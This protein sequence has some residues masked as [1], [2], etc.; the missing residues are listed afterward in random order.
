[1]T[2]GDTITVT[3]PDGVTVSGVTSGNTM[4]CTLTVFTG[5]FQTDPATTCLY[6]D[7]GT[8]TLAITFTNSYTGIFVINLVTGSNLQNPDSVRFLSSFTVVVGSTT[9]S[10]HGAIS[11]TTV[12]LSSASVANAVQS[13]GSA[14]TMTFTFRISNP[15]PQDGEIRINWPSEV[16]F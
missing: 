15:I 5:T 6:T 2:A 9:I 11:Y 14:T 7:S 1:M 4:T 10:T 12:A 8:R 3:I 13:A 16:Q